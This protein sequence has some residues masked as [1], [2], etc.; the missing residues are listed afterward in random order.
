MTGLL[1]YIRSTDYRG[2]RDSRGW[3]AR[4]ALALGI[5]PESIRQAILAHADRATES[6]VKR[7]LPQLKVDGFEI[8]VLRQG[9]LA[10]VP[11]PFRGYTP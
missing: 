11:E 3:A 10:E 5:D 1:D 2:N 4:R 7:M 6:I 8:D 9:D